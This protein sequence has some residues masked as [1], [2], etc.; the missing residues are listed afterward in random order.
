MPPLFHIDADS[1]LGLRDQLRQKLVNAILGGTFSPNERLPSSRQLAGQLRIARNTVTAAYQQLIDE[2][3]LVARERSGL[4]VNPEFIR[5]RFSTKSSERRAAVGASH[6]WRERLPTPTEGLKGFQYP[7]DWQSYPY[8][9][10]DGRFDRSLFPVAEWREANRLSLAVREVQ[11]W[12]TDA[13]DADD[14]LL[15][16]QIRTKVLPQRGITAAPEE[17]LV[18][19]GAQQALHL[20]SEVLI[21]PG[22]TCG[23]EEPGSPEMRYLALRR[24]AAVKALPTDE[25]GVIVDRGLDGCNTIHVT[26]SHQRPTGAVL[27]FERRRDL[28]ARAAASDA[29]ILEEDFEFDITDRQQALPALKS[30][31]R[32]GR[33]VY[34]A[35]LSKVL[36]ASLRLGVVVGAPE[37]IAA[38]RSLRRV[39]AGHA[40]LNNQRTAAIFLSLGHYNAMTVRL[41][42]VFKERL[43]ALR[44]ALNHYLQHFLAIPPLLSGTTYWVRG[45]EA[46]DVSELTKHAAARGV[47]IEPVE[48]YFA[49]GGSASNVFRMGITSL[50]VE[51][52]RA[53]VAALAET[54]RD[55]QVTDEQRLSAKEATLLS[56][57]ALDAALRGVTLFCKTVY[58]EP[59]TIDLHADGTMSGRAGYAGED[60]DTGRWW[61]EGDRWFRQWRSWAYGEP[62]GYHVAVDGDRIRW[63]N[64]ERKLVDAALIM[65]PSGHGISS[66]GRTPD[67]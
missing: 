51:R 28:L 60:R 67:A 23:V 14:P 9:F 42:R 44:E 27:S 13:G 52:I 21:A 57:A 18:T 38:A 29:I 50:P 7:P 10:I 45:P 12:S 25:Q 46:L 17:I 6:A 24:G 26:P 56:G 39:T 20:L 31:D 4:Y 41:N 5:D 61:V 65:R 55:M 15:I 33:V 53:G 62:N 11:Q 54:L 22:S 34:V 40:P 36:D 32:S 58:G 64:G 19:M 48:Q 3:Y 63:F 30:M 47:I 43:F 49:T 59:Y 66:E 2:G 37:V 8:P 35:S 1:D 16:E